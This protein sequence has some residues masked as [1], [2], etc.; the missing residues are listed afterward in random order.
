MCCVLKTNTTDIFD[1]IFLGKG[2][3][4]KNFNGKAKVPAIDD[5]TGKAEKSISSIM[6]FKHISFPAT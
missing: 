6:L 5:V 3:T 1:K 4:M 2:I